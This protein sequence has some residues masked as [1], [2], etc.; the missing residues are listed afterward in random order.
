MGFERVADVL[1]LA[2]DFR[3][4]DLKLGY[5]FRGTDTRYHILS[6]RIEEEFSVEDFFACSGISR[7]GDA[8]T[9]VVAGV[10]KDHGLDIDGGAPLVRDVVFPA[11][12]DGAIIIP[13]TEDGADRA[14]ELFA[15]VFGEI[16]ACPFADE[17]TESFGQGSEGRGVE[18]GVGDMGILGM[19]L[20]F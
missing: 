3:H 4:F 19:E 6:L 20:F 12:N 5:G 9:A 16:L 18:F 1:E 8:G 11:I 14:T 15:R 17:R 2:E 10:A 13:R 7:K